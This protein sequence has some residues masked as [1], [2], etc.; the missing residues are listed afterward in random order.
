[1][2]DLEFELIELNDRIKEIDTE[3]QSHVEDDIWLD[4]EVSKK[5]HDE[6]NGLIKR[7]ETL[8]NGNN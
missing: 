3:I 6:I 8:Q 1:M 5:L 2:Q 7:R 4:S